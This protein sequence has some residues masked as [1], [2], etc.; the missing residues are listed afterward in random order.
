MSYVSKKLL[1][2]TLSAAMCFSL[3]APALAAEGD[4]DAQA[5]VTQE[6]LEERLGGNYLYDGAES[7]SEDGLTVQAVISALLSWSGMEE[8][9]LGEYPRDYIAMADSMGMVDKD[10]ESFD[11]TALCTEAELEDMME[12]AQVLY[13][14]LHPEDGTMEPLFMNGMA[15]PIFPYTSGA[16]EEGYSNAESDIIRFFVYVETNYDTDGDGKLDLVKTLVQ[17]P[18]AAPTSPAAPP[19]ARP[20][21]TRAMIWRPCT[22]SRT[23]VYR[24][25]RLP[26]WTWQRTRTPASGITGIPTSGCTTT[27]T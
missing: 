18:R 1:S 27:R 15:Q 16:V 13:D 14:A 4:A 3:A 24:K 23:P 7:E 2:L 11:S 12:E 6:A 20:T 10:D 21:E 25:A 8:R 17:L 9:Q 5:S 22:A 19:A 26:R